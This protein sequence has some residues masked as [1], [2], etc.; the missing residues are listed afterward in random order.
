[1]VSYLYPNML[2]AVVFTGLLLALG[3]AVINPMTDSFNDATDDGLISEQ[4]QNS[5]NW[6]V[7]VWKIVLPL[8]LLLIISAW[9]IT[10]T[11]KEES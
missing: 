11:N 3:A 10:N 4:T 1:M 8:C 9:G 2:I 7:R 5:Y 6:I